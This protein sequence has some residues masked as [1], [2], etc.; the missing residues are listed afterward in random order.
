[1]M[2]DLGGAEYGFFSSDGVALP[3]RLSELRG[4]IRQGARDS[5]HRWMKRRGSGQAGINILAR[6]EYPRVR[7]NAGVTIFNIQVCYLPIGKPIRGEPPPSLTSKYRPG[8]SRRIRAY[9]LPM[10]GFTPADAMFSSDTIDFKAIAIST[11]A[12]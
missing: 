12:S 5:T 11:R 7:S 3:S 9:G 10:I 2:E 8:P 4:S 1:M 6:P